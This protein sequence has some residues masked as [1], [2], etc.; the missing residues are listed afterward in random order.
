M[1]VATIS[2]WTANTILTLTF[3]YLVQKYGIASPFGIYAVICIVIVLFV[4]RYI[5][6][7]KGKSLEQIEKELVGVPQE[8]GNPSQWR[9]GRTHD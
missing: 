2:L 6:E 5:P 4:V 7:T 9:S 3:P 1:G 8:T